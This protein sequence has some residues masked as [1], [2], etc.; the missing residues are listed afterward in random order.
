MLTATILLNL[1][2]C[3]KSMTRQVYSSKGL[4]IVIGQ[5]K[6]N[7]E[8]VA[9][10]SSEDLRFIDKNIDIHFMNVYFSAEELNFILKNKMPNTLNLIWSKSLFI[11]E[12]QR[13]HGIYHAGVRSN[14]RNKPHLPDTLKETSAIVRQGNLMDLAIPVDYFDDQVNE[15]VQSSGWRYKT[16]SQ[17]P[18]TEAYGDL[19]SLSEEQAQ[20]QVN[21]FNSNYKIDFNRLYGLRFIFETLSE[22]PLDPRSQNLTYEFSFVAQAKPVHAIYRSIYYD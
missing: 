9:N 21:D 20:K 1:G 3:R 15:R 10:K 8:V 4:K 2:A 12:R 5:V 16:L 14:I 19:W 17:K 6:L 18:S 11:D 13:Q 7:G 22:N